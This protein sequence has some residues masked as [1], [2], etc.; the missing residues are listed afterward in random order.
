M[1]GHGGSTESLGAPRRALPPP[2]NRRVLWCIAGMASTVAG[3][4]QAALRAW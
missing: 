4:R 2:T 1:R 3:Q